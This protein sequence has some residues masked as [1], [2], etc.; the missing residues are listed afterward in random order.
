MLEGKFLLVQGRKKVSFRVTRGESS[1]SG[2]QRG[3][4]ECLGCILG[5][6]LTVVL[7]L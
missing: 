4:Q 2:T 6:R 3:W 5:G 7:I 1:L